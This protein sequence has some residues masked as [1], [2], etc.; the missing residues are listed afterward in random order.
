MRKEDTAAH[1]KQPRQLGFTLA[2]QSILA[3]W[4]LLAT[5][6]CANAPALHQLL[7]ARIAA[8]SVN[9]LPD[10]LRFCLPGGENA[11]RP[12]RAGAVRAPKGRYDGP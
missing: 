5:G 11:L 7:L 10:A 9:N 3:S 1:H 2:C 6:A 8:N 4:M 12:R